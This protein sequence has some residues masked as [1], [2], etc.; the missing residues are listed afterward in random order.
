LVYAATD[1][2]VEQGGYYGPRF[3]LVGSPHKARLPRTV[4]ADLAARL[5]SEAERITGVTT[6]T[7]V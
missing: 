7:S 1:S 2:G 5:W 4:D 6:P 3:G